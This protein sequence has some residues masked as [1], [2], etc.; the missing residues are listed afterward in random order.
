MGGGAFRWWTFAGGRANAT[1]VGLVRSG[2]RNLR[3]T[4][5]YVEGQGAFDWQ[6]VR[7][8]ADAADPTLL[9]RQVAKSAPPAVKFWPLCLRLRSRP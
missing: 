2:F 7:I 1:L 9:A 5:F 8:L 6:Q 4:D 3:A